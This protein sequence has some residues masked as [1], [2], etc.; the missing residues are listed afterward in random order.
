MY[1]RLLNKIKQEWRHSSFGRTRKN[2]NPVKWGIIGLGYMAEVFSTAI[3]G[4]KD[5]VVAAVASRSINKAKQFAQNHGNC[6]FYGSYIDMISDKSIN[7]DVVYIAT[8][9]KCHFEHVKLCLEAGYN[10]LCEK[11]ITFDIHQ[12][13]ELRSIAKEN[14]CFLMEAMWMK[15]LPTF[16][17]SVSWLSSNCIG[18]LELIKA[19]FY[20]HSIIDSKYSIYNIEDGGGIMNDFGVYALSF[21]SFFLQVQPEQVYAYCRK[22]CRGLDADWL[23]TAKAEGVQAIANLSN[24]FKSLSKASLIGTNGVIQFESQFNRTNIVT[25]Y[26]AN[27]V[28]IERYKAKYKFEGFEYEV[29]EVQRCIRQGLKESTL[30]PIEQTI[31]T[32]ILIDKIKKQL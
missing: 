29:N 30:A 16:Q 26:N 23:I 5:G 18:K 2:S 7:L 21:I 24:N 31:S 9:V 17:K 19:D 12:L 11:P 15:C 10:V 25:L 20:K 22:D 32:F 27:G 14:D 8:P 6:N 13:Q 28:L 1:Q 4:N 3:D